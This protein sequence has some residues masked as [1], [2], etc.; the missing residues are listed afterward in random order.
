M[1]IRVDAI[2]RNKNEIR[3]Q[4]RIASGGRTDKRQRARNRVAR[5]EA[6]AEFNRMEQFKKYLAYR[7]DLDFDSNRA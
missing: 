3:K 6:R 2:I 4:N 1:T 7:E 5:A